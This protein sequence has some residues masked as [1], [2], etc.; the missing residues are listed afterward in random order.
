M[1]KSPEEQKLFSNYGL[2]LHEMLNEIENVLDLEN[3]KKSRIC[4]N[5][6]MKIDKILKWG[7]F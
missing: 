3:D 6:L 2:T 4:F 1:T 7:E 5:K